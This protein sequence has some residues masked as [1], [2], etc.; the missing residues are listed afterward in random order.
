MK[1]LK[2][3]FK[4]IIIS[5][6]I[7]LIC[8]QLIFC[9]DSVGSYNLCSPTT[10]TLRSIIR[11]QQ[12]KQNRKRLKK[13]EIFPNIRLHYF[14]GEVK[15]GVSELKNYSIAAY[16]NKWGL[17]HTKSDYKSRSFNSIN[18]SANTDIGDIIYTF[19][20]KWTLSFGI[21]IPTNGEAEITFLNHKYTSTSISG[22]GI[23]AGIGIK[24]W[25]FE[26]L[27]RKT[28]LEY[29]Y[30]NF[31]RDKSITLKEGLKI[32]ADVLSLGIGLNF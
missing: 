31:L 15:S 20:K 22:H 25:F 30:S 14:T 28:A 21:S 26:I 6:L 12:Q 4:F 5:G 18:F 2:I 16:W 11:H 1:F 24:L 19:G 32:K 23:N 9:A 13:S 3:K 7:C 29:E 10:N 27:M 8:P 17:G